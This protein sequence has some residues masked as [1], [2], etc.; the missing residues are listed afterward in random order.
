MLQKRSY[1]KSKRL[2]LRKESH[3]W[4][5]ESRFELMLKKLCDL[6]KKKRVKKKI[7]L[8]MV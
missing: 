5:A 2:T 6:G 8:S 7:R 4:R 1:V 3:G